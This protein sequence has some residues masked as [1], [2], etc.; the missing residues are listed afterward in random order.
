[1]WEGSDDNT[2][3]G[4]CENATVGVG[5]CISVVSKKIALD[6]PSASISSVGTQA[7]ESSE[8]WRASMRVIRSN[9]GRRAGDCVDPFRRA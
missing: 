5:S 6:G 8:L 9:N 1:M 7:T 4:V 3:K 2:D